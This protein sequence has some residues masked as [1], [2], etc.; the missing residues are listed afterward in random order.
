MIIKLYISFK[1]ENSYVME[2]ISSKIY[3]VKKEVKLINED[4]TVTFRYL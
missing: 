3:N 2:D 4:L 1:R